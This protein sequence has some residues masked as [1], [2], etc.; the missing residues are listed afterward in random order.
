MGVKSLPSLSST[1]DNDILSVQPNPFTE[2][3]SIWIR[4]LEKR[5]VCI[6]IID[7]RG[8]LVE[9][10]ARENFNR[11]AHQFIWNADNRPDGIYFIKVKTG[12]RVYGRRIILLR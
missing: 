11:G 10:L 2:S 7:M 1:N 5:E 4:L 8:K 3:T 12:S 6:D 9:R